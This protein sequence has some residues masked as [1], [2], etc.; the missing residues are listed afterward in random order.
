MVEFQPILKL[1][2]GE[3]WSQ[4]EMVFRYVGNINMH[5]FECKTMDALR[6]S[7]IARIRNNIIMCLNKPTCPPSVFMAIETGEYMLDAHI[8]SVTPLSSCEKVLKCQVKKPPR[9]P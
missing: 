1:S 7:L 4:R 2:H 9:E 6:T 8:I 3:S 5:I